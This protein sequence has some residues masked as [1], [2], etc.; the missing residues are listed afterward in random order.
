MNL[1][2]LMEKE[3]FTNTEKKYS[4]MLNKFQEI[5][6]I[7]TNKLSKIVDE[8]RKVLEKYQPYTDATQ[9]RIDKL[10]NGLEL[11]IHNLQK[12]IE[13]SKLK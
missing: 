13:Q 11:R 4:E 5:Y 12:L 10:C 2:S 3:F 7:D 8:Y 6:R 9:E 1:I